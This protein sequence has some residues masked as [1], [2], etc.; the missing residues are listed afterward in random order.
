MDIWPKKW[1]FSNSR[2]RRTFWQYLS[3]ILANLCKFRNGDEESQADIGH[4]TKVAIFA[5]SRWRRAA[6]LKIALYTYLSRNYPISS[7]FG[8]PMQF[9]IP[10]MAIWQKIRFF[11]IQNGG[12]TPY[13]KSFFFCYIS[14]PYWRIDVKFEKEMKNHMPIQVT[15]PKLQFSQIEDGGRPRFWKQF[16]V[17]TSFL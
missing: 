7:K 1:N 3:A 2:W 9:S 8:M 12:R 13:W 17:F 15:W 6:I 14:A 4:L 5:N 16:S 10:R 11:Q